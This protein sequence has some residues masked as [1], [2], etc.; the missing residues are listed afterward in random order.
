MDPLTHV[1]L[2]L[3][4][5]YAVRPELFA[6]P[7]H[8][9]VAGFGLVPDL[10]KFVGQQ[11]LLHALPA[12]SVLAIALLVGERRLTGRRTYA[13]L[14]VA[15][16]ASH[17]LL[18]F[19]DGGP[20]PLLFPFVKTGAGLTYPMTLTFGEGPLGVVVRGP[21][22]ALRSGAPRT[23]HQSFGGIVTS[24]GIASVLTFLGVLFGR[25]RERGT[26][27]SDG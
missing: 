13:A 15:F 26:I 18:D 11:G 10:D 25:T 4:V 12:L 6:A 14:A 8:F 22:V 27:P 23:G 7:R 2:P 17:L 1:F 9:A 3:T 16:L 5:A 20:V 21:P 24:T 19:L